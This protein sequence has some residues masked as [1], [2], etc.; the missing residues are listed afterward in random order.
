MVSVTHEAFRKDF[1]LDL[2]LQGGAIY[3]TKCVFGLTG[4]HDGQLINYQLLTGVQHG[5]LINFQPFSVESR[6]ISTGLTPQKRCEFKIDDSA[7][8]QSGKVKELIK[9][10]LKDWG[11]FLCIELYRDAVTH[12]LGG[13]GRALRPVNILC[14]KQV[15]GQ[16]TV[17]LLNDRTALHLS[18]MSKRL[19]SYETHLGRLLAHMDVDAIQWVNFDQNNIHFKTIRSS[20]E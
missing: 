15:I 4:R 3:E 5:K 2:L 12:F 6:F 14:D 10:L 19:V 18:A 17:C 9:T 8:E 13:E 11:A 7:C 1:Y 20:S 16:K